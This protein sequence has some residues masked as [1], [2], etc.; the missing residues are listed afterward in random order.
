MYK[1]NIKAALAECLGTFGL[2][3][4]VLSAIGAGG[5]FLPTP[6]LAAITLGLFVAT[7]GPV[8]GTHINPA[9]TLGLY[10]N[11]KIDTGTAVTYIVAQILGALLAALVLGIAFDVEPNSIIDNTW[12][13]AL[14]EGL[15][16]FFFTFGIGAV[17]N[18]WTTKTQAPFAVG[19][20]LLIGISVAS[21]ASNGVL[22]PAVGLAIQSFN[23][24]YL[25]GPILGSIIGFFVADQLLGQSK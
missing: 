24:A 4:V 19:L 7:I 2:T 10:T 25:F 12:R 13:V 17:V 3:Y 21:L 11:R 9:V 22:N 5:S 14:A 16:M 6:L 18:G 20:S 15:G 23:V 8:S 1:I